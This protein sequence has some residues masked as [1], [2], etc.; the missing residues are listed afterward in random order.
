MG[1]HRSGLRVAA[2]TGRP[3]ST[4]RK[5][6]KR[7]RIIRARNRLT[8]EGPVPPPAPFVCG[9]TRSGTTLVR[10]MLDSHPDLAIPG[11]TH[12]VPKLIRRIEKDRMPPEDLADVIIES[13]RWQEFHL[14][15]D[16]LRERD[17]RDPEGGN[18]ADAIRAF[19]VALRRARGQDAL[20]RQDSRLHQ[21]DGAD[22]A[23]PP[24]GA[25]HPHHSR[26]PR[27]L[28]LPH[29]DELGPDDLRGVGEAVGRADREGARMAPKIEH[30]NEVKFEDL[31]RDTEG[32]L[33][34]VCEIIELDF[35]PVM[36]DYHERAEK[37]LQEKNVDLV[38]RHGPTQP[39]EA[40]MESHKL[41]K[42]PPQ[43][44][45]LGAWREKMTEEEIASY[46]RSP[47]RCCSSWATN[48]RRAAPAA[49]RARE[50]RSSRGPSRAQ[51]AARRA[52]RGPDR[53]SR[54]NRPGAAAFADTAIAVLTIVL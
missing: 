12:W 48:Y 20:R 35:D 4:Y 49:L 29:A 51:I 50:A 36:L 45:R 44:D 53:R 43:K 40:R 23:H 16:A 1:A 28:A 2:R 54:R 26:R 11:E 21:G 7:A 3:V 27:R 52:R 30:Y 24:R 22:P 17:R 33:R 47:A 9:V 32:T 8:S 25:I 15:P 38:R 34:K 31:V 46:E 41:A 13:K 19:Y 14:D 42:E 37:R 39:A 18:A 10:L 5:L 6:K